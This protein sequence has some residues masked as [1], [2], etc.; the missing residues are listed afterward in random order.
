MYMVAAVQD[1]Y[2]D[3]GL[4]S[5][6]GVQFRAIHTRWPAPL[7]DPTLPR[8]QIGVSCVARYNAETVF[9]WCWSQ[10]SRW[11]LQQIRY[12]WASVGASFSNCRCTCI[13]EPFGSPY[14]ATYGR[15]L[16]G[17]FLRRVDHT[18]AGFLARFAAIGLL[19]TANRR[20]SEPDANLPYRD[21]HQCKYMKLQRVSK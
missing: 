6:P 10:F 11:R 14:I 5:I 20:F 19:T 15:Q 7:L 18:D 8:N 9:I 4:S 16:T 17:Q 21:W 12:D 3:S 2:S 1:C 13:S